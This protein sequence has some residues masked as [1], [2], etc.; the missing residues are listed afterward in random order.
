MILF[1]LNQTQFFHCSCNVKLK[2]NSNHFKANIKLLSTF[3]KPKL[4]YSNCLI[5]LTSGPNNEWFS[6]NFPRKSRDSHVFVAAKHL[7]IVSLRLGD[8]TGWSTWRY[9]QA[10]FTSTFELKL[11]QRQNRYL[12]DYTDFFSPGWLKLIKWIKFLN[13]GHYHN[14]ILSSSIQQHLPHPP[15]WEHCLFK[16]RSAFMTSSLWWPSVAQPRQHNQVPSPRLLTYA[17]MQTQKLHTS[18][19]TWGQ[20]ERE[21]NNK[22]R[23]C[24]A[25][26]CPSQRAQGNGVAPDTSNPASEVHWCVLMATVQKA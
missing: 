21:S 20:K 14:L 15:L 13:M 4:L 10:R 26:I 6:V 1:L 19:H 23:P 16:P 25:F 8:A 2:V 3:L 9:Q 11:N 24:A 18:T 22:A 7:M 12:T 17:H 5:C